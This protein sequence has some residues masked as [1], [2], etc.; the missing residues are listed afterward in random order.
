MQISQP[1]C[2]WRKGDL[3]ERWGLDE[4][5]DSDQIAAGFVMLKKTSETMELVERWYRLA[6]VDDHH[7]LDDSASRRPNHPRFCEHRHDQAILSAL[8]K[9][10]GFHWILQ[11]VDFGRRDRVR[12]GYPI[13]AMRNQGMDPIGLPLWERTATRIRKSVSTAWRK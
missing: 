12:P 8:L 11:E 3:T 7:V 13:R 1:E 6:I 2:V 5:D 10:R 9:K 4:S